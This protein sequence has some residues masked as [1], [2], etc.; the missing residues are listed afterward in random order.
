MII[1]FAETFMDIRHRGIS[2]VCAS[3]SVDKAK[4]KVRGTN[5]KA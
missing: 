1:G 3:H 5:K 4:P 2:V